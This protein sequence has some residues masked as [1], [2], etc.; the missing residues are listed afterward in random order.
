M[1]RV[2]QEGLLRDVCVAKCVLVSAFLIPS[3]T[4]T[5]VIK[6]TV[7]VGEGAGQDS[8]SASL[9]PGGGQR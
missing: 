7:R 3:S 6:E 1:L 2:T 8:P 5:V 9:G 4:V